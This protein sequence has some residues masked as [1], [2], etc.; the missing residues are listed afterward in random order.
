VNAVFD[1]LT[2][3]LL[4]VLCRQTSATSSLS[5]TMDETYDSDSSDGSIVIPSSSVIPE[6]S[7][8][9][10]PVSESYKANNILSSIT[11]LIFATGRRFRRSG[12]TVL[13]AVDGT[14]NRYRCCG[15]CQHKKILK[16]AEG[17][18][19]QA[20]RFTTY[21]IVISSISMAMISTIPRFRMRLPNAEI[22]LSPR[23]QRGRG[24]GVSS[25]RLSN[26]GHCQPS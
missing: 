20:T 25:P 18:E 13:N 12:G 14:F 24:Q 19:R 16:C 2:P 5:P 17:V 26:L 15:H 22:N 10:D 21:E 1:A 23:G 6:S 11:P 3:S 7:P 4:T 8:A 9:N